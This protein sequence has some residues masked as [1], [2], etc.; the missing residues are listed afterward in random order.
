MNSAYEPMEPARRPGGKPEEKPCYRVLV[1][2]KYE[3]AWEQIV[4]RVG[5][6]QAQQFWDHVAKTPGMKDP[7]AS[8]RPL[9]GKAGAPKEKGFSKTIHYEPG[10]YLF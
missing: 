1:H 8:T 6:Q 7:I 4:E 9:K 3:S 5:I 2:R 10:G